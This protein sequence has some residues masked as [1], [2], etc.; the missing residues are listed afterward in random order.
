[1]KKRKQ[2]LRK[3]KPIKEEFENRILK[4]IEQPERSDDADV[5]RQWPARWREWQ[6]S[7]QE[8]GRSAQRRR[9]GG[10]RHRD[11]QLGGARLAPRPEII[12]RG[13]DPA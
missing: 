10:G 13:G 8:R 3:N 7:G 12:E 4:K 9:L 11:Q 2:L 6:P 5:R 1:M